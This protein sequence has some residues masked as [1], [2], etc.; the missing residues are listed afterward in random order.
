MV[1]WSQ[2]WYITTPLVVIILG[3]WS[4]LLHGE[5]FHLI[6]FNV[7][8]TPSSGILL[9]ADWDPVQ[10]CV[11][12]SVNNLI[13]IITFI[14]SMT[15]DFLVLS[16]SAYKLIWSSTWDTGRSKLVILLFRDGLIYFIVA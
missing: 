13:L 4:L 12:T 10:G 5:P 6:L 9:K 8:H 3:H 1:I 2:K 11:I 14:Y 7:Y 16:L 15:L